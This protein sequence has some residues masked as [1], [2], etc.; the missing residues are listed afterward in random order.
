LSECTETASLIVS[1]RPLFSDVTRMRKLQ[2]DGA[3]VS[4]C[5]SA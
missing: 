1:M 2:G 5:A 3:L 4:V